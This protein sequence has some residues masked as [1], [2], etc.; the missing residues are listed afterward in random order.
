MIADLKPYPTYRD[1]G[2]PWLGQVPGHWEILPNRALFN[3][4]KERDHPHEEMLS[5]TITE[6]IVKQKVLLEDSSKKDRSNLDKSAYKLVQPRDIAY[7][8][9]RAWQGA[10]GAS[11]LRGIISPAYVV[12]RLRHK[13][14]FPRYG[15]PQCQDHGS[16]KVC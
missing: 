6:G 4:V 12:M 3:E 8:K 13:K 1:S 16:G 7:N 15:G 2:L 10:I 5:V 9:M 14:S 11:T